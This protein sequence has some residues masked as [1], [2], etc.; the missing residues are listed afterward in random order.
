MAFPSCL[1]GYIP[2][3]FWP[4]FLRAAEISLRFLDGVDNN[5]FKKTGYLLISH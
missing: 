5:A 1:M 3:C 4:C 2:V